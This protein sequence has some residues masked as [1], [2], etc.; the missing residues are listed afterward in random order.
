MPNIVDGVL[1][2]IDSFLAWLSAGLKQTTESYCDLETADSPYVLVGHDGSL[3]SI[4]KVEGAT[5]LIGK[6]EFAMMHE[7]L[8]TS[9][10]T[11]MS[12][13]GHSIQI[14]F[15][16][17]REQVRE[18]I[19]DIYI[20]AIETAKRLNLK[21]DDVFQER[22]D[23]LSSYCA[24]EDVYFAL[25]T[26]PTLLRKEEM[27]R[28]EK[29]KAKELREKKMPPFLRTQNI[30]AAIHELRDAHDAFVRAMVNDMSSVNLAVQLYPVKKA[31]HA[32]R[33]TVDP[34]YTDRKW[35]PVLPGDKVKPK[36]LKSSRGDI[37]DLLWP[38]LAK[39]IIPRDA[40]NIDLRTVR[41]GDKIY[42]CVFIDLFPKEVRQFVSLFARTLPTQIPWRMSFLLDSE[43][44]SSLKIKSML[45]SVLA[46][47]SKQNRLLSDGVNLVRY[48]ELN[49]DDA[50]VR[51]RVA[52][53]TWAPEG[54]F[55][56]FRQTKN[57]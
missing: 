46:F 48:I 30:V 9:L 33:M 13:P 56:S 19:N 17:D 36:E 26:F 39:Q 40:E 18:Q 49:T 53:T 47:S 32:I 52:A 34:E 16:Y 23:Y 8:T 29:E 35:E 7:G 27:Q 20:P 21:L 31:V 28:A 54:D 2:G 1:D 11:A 42:S 44:T 25:W 4:I 55:C 37:S 43:G 51:L 14:T 24:K 10:Q 3:V 38:S 15:S 5:A 12:R 45:S 41:L 22:V 6:P 50:V 57:L